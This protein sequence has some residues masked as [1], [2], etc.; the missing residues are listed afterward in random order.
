MKRLTAVLLSVFLLAVSV[1][2]ASGDVNGDDELN[3]KDVVSL[4]RYV[5]GDKNAVEDESA[6][7]INGD[8]GIDN[9]D[10][11]SLFRAVSS[12]ITP[13]ETGEEAEEE[14]ETVDTEKEQSEDGIVRYPSNDAE[15]KFDNETLEN[16]ARIGVNSDR[17][18]RHVCPGESFQFRF[19]A[20]YDESIEISLKDVDLKIVSGEKFGTLSD[21]G[22]FTAVSAGAVTLEAALKADESKKCSFTVTVKEPDQTGMTHWQGSGTYNDPYL[23]NNVDDF[24]NL[25]RI[26]KYENF[27]SDYNK[28]GHWFKQ[29]ADIDFSGISYEPP[30]DVIYNYNGDGHKILNV[31]V[32]ETV[33]A[34]GLFGRTRGSVIENVTLENYTFK[35]NNTVSVENVG[36]FSSAVYGGLFYN[37]RAVNIEIDT[38]DNAETW[39]VGGFVGHCTET[40]SFVNCTTSGSIKC[41]RFAGGFFGNAEMAAWHSIF[42]N[43]VS[44]VTVEAEE[45]TYG[46]FCEKAN[47]MLYFYN[48]KSTQYD[49]ALEDYNIEVE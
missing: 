48:C 2:A 18:I 9:K 30:E 43:C 16:I 14:T 49:K 24:M 38:T 15:H 21:D 39:C 45:E 4:F 29:T 46:G 33:A 37:C 28:G 25:V 10:V 7:D 8:G 19:Y 31:T 23:I 35:R 32:D 44:D 41:D 6:C 11:V 12:N 13:V 42:V 5:S 3:N 27:N 20:M 17:N 40:T 1:L 34:P 26:C 47:E 36:V 22:V